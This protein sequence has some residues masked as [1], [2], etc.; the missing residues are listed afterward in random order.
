MEEGTKQKQ[1]YGS[2]CHHITLPAY[3]PRKT[4]KKRL[5]APEKVSYISSEKCFIVIKIGFGAACPKPQIEA[6]CIAV[7][8]SPSNG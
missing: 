6:S 1:A 8:N 2:S 3:R 4:L 7:H 5:K